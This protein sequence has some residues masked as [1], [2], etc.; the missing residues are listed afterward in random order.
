M[1]RET[2][3]CRNHHTL[4]HIT[5]LR[6]ESQAVMLYLYALVAA[7]VVVDDGETLLEARRAEADH[8][9]NQLGH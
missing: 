9:T 2:K 7:G 3:H 1:L 8:N 5:T 4:L 6:D